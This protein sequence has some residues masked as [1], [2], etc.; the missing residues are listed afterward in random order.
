MKLFCS[1]RDLEFGSCMLG[2]T[3]ANKTLL[4]TSFAPQNKMH[5]LPVHSF[6]LNKTMCCSRFT[7]EARRLSQGTQAFPIHKRGVED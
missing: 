6:K 4:F 3:R 5:P 2:G 1:Y 7:T